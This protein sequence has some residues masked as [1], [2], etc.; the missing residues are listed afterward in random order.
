MKMKV[1]WSKQAMEDIKGIFDYRESVAGSRTARKIIKKIHARP[2]IL[3][4]NPQAGQREESLEDLPVEFRRLV[5][6]NHKIVYFIDETTVVI[7]TIFDCHRDPTDLRQ[8]ITH[9]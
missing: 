6:G 1:E 5:E 3:V 4:K 9:N 8:S 7:S 2:D